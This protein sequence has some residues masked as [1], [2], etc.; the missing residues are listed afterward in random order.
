[1]L[2]EVRAAIE[3]LERRRHPVLTLWSIPHSK[4]R[5]NRTQRDT[6]SERKKAPTAAAAT[7]SDKF[8][9]DNIELDTIDP[10]PYMDDEKEVDELT[11]QIKECRATEDKNKDLAE[12]L[13]R[14]GALYRQ[15]YTLKYFVI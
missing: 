4:T 14:R 11:N 6:R 15:V 8:R 3:E 12:F 7:A 5:T 9:L 1:M 2:A 10:L 13:V